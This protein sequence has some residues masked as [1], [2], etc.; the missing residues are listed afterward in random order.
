LDRFGTNIDI[1]KS[2]GRG[3]FIRGWAY[4]A[5]DEAGQVVDYS[6]DVLGGLT[7][8]EGMAEV[9]KMAHAFVC[10][11]RTARLVHKGKAIG[12]VVESVV[13]DDEIAKVLGITTKRRGW[14]IGMRIDDEA[15]QKSVRDG[16]LRQF[17]IGGRGKRTAL[18]GAR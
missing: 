13:I 14:F 11:F 5:A 4:V 2:D 10:D 3:Q 9:K 1:I 16:V 8:E 6:G 12:E 17:S 7:V 15:V 18:E